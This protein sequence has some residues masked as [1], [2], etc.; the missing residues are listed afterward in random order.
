M[1]HLPGLIPGLTLEALSPVYRTEPQGV[2]DQPW[3]ANQVARLR[4]PVPSWESLRRLGGSS[5][6]AAG[7][8]F[9]AEIQARELMRALLDLESR[10]GREREMSAKAWGPRLIDLDLL[11]FDGVACR[12]PDLILPH[13]RLL[14]RAFVLAPLLDIDPDLILPDGTSV[15]K[16]L[17]R[18][19]YRL[20][21]GTI[22]QS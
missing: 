4:A 22:W 10:L 20:E 16:A 2:K 3:F 1:E 11:L 19:D 18:L 7:E 14:E 15:R 9:A 8:V 5:P 21:N 6:L 13:P 17:E 12:H